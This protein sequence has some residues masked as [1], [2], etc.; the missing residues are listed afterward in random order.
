[1]KWLLIMVLMISGCTGTARLSVYYPER[2][3]DEAE[4]RAAEYAGFNSFSAKK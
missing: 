3:G 2:L 4:S 1:M